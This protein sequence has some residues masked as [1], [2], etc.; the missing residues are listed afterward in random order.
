I[1]A[2]KLD[3]SVYAHNPVVDGP[4][5]VD[6]WD[7][8]TQMVLVPNPCYTLTAPPLLKR[9]VVKFISDTNQVVAQ[10]KTG[11]L[12]AAPYLGFS[13]T[14]SPA[15]D[16]LASSGQ[17]VEYTSI[18]GWEHLDFNLDRPQF[19]DK[20]VRQAILTGINRRQIIDKVLLGKGGIFNTYLP[21]ANWASM[22]N[23]DFAAIWRSKFPINDYNFDPARANKM[24]DDAGWAKGPDGIRGKNG[25]RLV[26]DYATTQGNPQRQQV[27][28]MVAADLKNI[29]MQ[30]N[31]KYIPGSTLFADLGPLQKRQFDLVEF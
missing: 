6:H 2:D 18:L 21:P 14:V 25:V 1:P 27:T 9:I 28:Q 16:A 30:A 12:D 17:T 20:V 22:D 5:K 8:G 3:A 15:L 23:P 13:G 4:F 29:G 10:L 19:Q 31:L 26:F 24:L 11:D 7:A